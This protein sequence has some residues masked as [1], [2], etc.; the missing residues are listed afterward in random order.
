MGEIFICLGASQREKRFSHVH[1][2]KE[3]QAIALARAFSLMD[4]QVAISHSTVRRIIR[5][6]GFHPYKIQQV[7]ALYPHDR[8]DQ[9]NFCHWILNKLQ[10]EPHFLKRVLF[11][12]EC[13]FYDNNILNSQNARI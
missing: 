13:S 11:I 7:Q 4:R 3:K 6:E 5:R 12:D 1:W 2:W 10:R 9:R 8:Y